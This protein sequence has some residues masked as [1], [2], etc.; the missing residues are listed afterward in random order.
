MSRFYSLFSFDQKM[1]SFDQK[2]MASVT[3][4][5]FWCSGHQN[6]NSRRLAFL[7]LRSSFLAIYSRNPRFSRD[8]L[9]S[10]CRVYASAIEWNRLWPGPKSLWRNHSSSWKFRPEG[11]KAQ[12]TI[13]L[14]QCWVHL[15]IWV[16][17]SVWC[18]YHLRA[19]IVLNYIGLEQGGA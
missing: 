8:L 15:S 19:W 3:G 18:Y 13:R 17:L 14:F 7:F 5:H 6:I 11:H 2:T 4:F 16:L 10:L 1:F 9:T 12:S